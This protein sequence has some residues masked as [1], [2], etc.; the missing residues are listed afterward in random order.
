MIAAP[1][2]PPGPTP[3]TVAD[4][5]IADLDT[6]DAAEDTLSEE[7]R[8]RAARFRFSH[9]RRRFCAART[10][11]RRLLGDRLGV[12]ASALRFGAGPYGKPFLL[13]PAPGQGL[14]PGLE[15]NVSHSGPMAVCAVAGQPLGVDIQRVNPDL[16]WP[17]LAQGFFA[18]GEYLAITSLPEAERR[19][20]FFACWTRKEALVKAAGLGLSHPLDAFEVSVDP[21]APPVL[22]AGAHPFAP[23]DW[24]LYE[25]A[26]PRGY[27]ACLAAAGPLDV[28]LRSLP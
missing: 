15:F 8:D 17:A 3:A 7:D 26:A 22:L 16:E 9:D 19:D 23:N 2:G 24:T 13:S 4:V 12:P 1:H 28:R 14:D 11:L 6:V 5:W 20:A 21:G 10:L 27:R 18:P 25:L